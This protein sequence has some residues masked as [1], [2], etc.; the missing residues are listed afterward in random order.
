MLVPG[1]LTSVILRAELKV[2]EH[3]GLGEPQFIPLLICA[4]FSEFPQNQCIGLIIYA[5][6]AALLPALFMVSCFKLP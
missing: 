6:T 2:N 1:Y 5:Y 3:I 4:L